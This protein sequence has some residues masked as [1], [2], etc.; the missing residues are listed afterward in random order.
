MEVTRVLD[1]V[2]QRRIENMEA[3]QQTQDGLIEY[4][5][6]MADVELPVEDEPEQ[7]GRPV[8]E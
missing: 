8:D 4:V 7:M 2:A 1:F 5:A 3:S 6:C